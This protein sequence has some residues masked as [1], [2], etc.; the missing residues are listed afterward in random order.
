MRHCLRTDLEG[1]FFIFII[2][3]IKKKSITTL[4]IWTEALGFKH[5]NQ[6]FLSNTDKDTE[7]EITASKIIATPIPNPAI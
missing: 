3:I 7:T 2:I 1:G 6:T 5:S 4:R